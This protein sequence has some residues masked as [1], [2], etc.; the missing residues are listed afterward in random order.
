MYSH[1]SKLLSHLF[2]YYEIKN[3]VSAQHNQSLIIVMYVQVDDLITYFLPNYPHLYIL[4]YN[5]QSHFINNLKILCYKLSFT[6][7][8]WYLIY[9]TAKT[10]TV[11]H[12][13][14]ERENNGLLFSSRL[15]IKYH[16]HFCAFGTRI[17]QWDFRLCIL[18]FTSSHTRAILYQ[19][20]F[21]TNTK[22]FFSLETFNI[23]KLHGK[24]MYNF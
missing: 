17:L 6:Y 10:I 19:N 14:N 1:M 12:C 7:V 11:H 9:I 8:Y 5:Y 23:N 18:F 3:I 20:Y 15:C 22:V 2:S 24:N 4:Y 13:E 16:K 21:S